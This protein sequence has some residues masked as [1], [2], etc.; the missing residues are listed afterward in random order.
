MMIANL[1]RRA[2]RVCPLNRSLLVLAGSVFL[3]VA[4][5][6]LAESDSAFSLNGF[7]TFGLARTTTDNVEFV[8]DISQP[9]GVGKDWSAL[10]DSVLGVQGA[11]H[12]SPQFEAVVQATSRYRYDK[13]FTPDISWG[14][15]KYN[16]TPNLSL[17]AG[18]L[19]TEFFMMA[20]SRWVGYSFLTVRPPGDYFW[21]LPFYSIHGADAAINLSLEEGV[22]RA[23]AFYGHS[24][25]KIPLADEQWDIAGSPM[26][27]GYLEYQRGPWQVRASY[28]N[29]EFK[30]D[31][32]I[33]PVLKKAVGVTLSAQDAAFL[34]THDTRTHYYSL[35][36]VYDRGPWQAQVMLNHIEQGSQALES[37]DGGYAL[38]GYRVGEVTP[39]LGYSWVLSRSRGNAPSAI[40]AYVMQDSHADQ[41]TTFAGLRWDFVRNVAV[42]AQWDGIRGEASSL[43]PYRQDNRARWDGR[44]DVFSLTVDFVF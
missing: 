33:A 27:G 25:G 14:F 38:V 5:P 9:R 29:I 30:N 44:M 19:G 6:V 22:L 12:I 13:T 43:F 26:L 24:N 4:P 3:A 10:I 17:R 16:P 34:A 41:Q 1:F 8:R 20:D 7:G 40:A 21:Y 11:W 36:V 28:A 23:K 39:Y 15:I 31:L 2:A 18:R 42:T 32:P 35:G 37:S